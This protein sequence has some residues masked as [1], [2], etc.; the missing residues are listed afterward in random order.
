MKKLINIIS[1]ALVLGTILLVSSCK[2]LDFTYSG[3]SLVSF[4]E[5]TSSTYYVQDNA[6][7]VDTVFVGVTSITGTDR[8]VQFS[9]DPASTAVPGTHYNLAGNTV[10]IPANQSRGAIIVNG[11]YDG[12]ADESRSLILNIE[13]GDVEIANFDTTHNLSMLAFCSFDINDFVGTWDVVDQSV[14]ED[15]PYIYQLT[16]EIYE[17]NTLL[18]TGLWEEDIP[19]LIELDGSDPGNF[20]AIIPE[21][22]YASHPD[23]GDMTIEQVTTGTFSSCEYIIWTSYMIYVDAGFFDQVN[24]SV[25]TKVVP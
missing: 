15:D 7:T 3:P 6:N 9:V 20:M 8:I 2:E 12:F 25:W 16:T 13:G 23:Y 17:D 22:Y 1:Y 4:A 11:I 19:V 21:Q 14:Y 5:G 10:V 24:S 18:V